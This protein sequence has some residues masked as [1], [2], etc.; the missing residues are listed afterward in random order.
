MSREFLLS[1]DLGTT[2]VRAI[3]FDAAGRAR[4][5]AFSP[6][7]VRYPSPGRVE[8]DATDMWDRSVEV[9]RRAIAEAG[10][11]AG[12]IAGIG[13]VTQRST[14]VAWDAETL[15]PIAPVIGWQDGR[16]AERVAGFRALGIPLN[17]LASATKFEWWM[18]NDDAVRAASSAGTLRL[19]TPDTWL[20]TKLTGGDA[21]VT[22]PGNAASTALF[23]NANGQWS[24][25]IV[26]LF[27]VPSAALAEVVPTNAIVGETP[28]DLLGAPVPVAARAGDQQASM[29]GQGAHAPG[30]EKI[31]LGTSAMVDVH[32]GDAP[33][34]AP[35]GAYALALWHLAGEARTYCLEGTVITAGSAI[36]WLIDLGLARDAEEAGALA[37]SVDTSAGVVFVPALQGLGTPFADDGARA[38]FYG[39]TRG[40]T[41][42]HLARAVLE[43][44]AHRCVDVGEALGLGNVAVRAG[45]GMARNDT[46]LQMIADYGGHDVLR[47]AEVEASALGAAFFA[48]IATGVFTGAEHCR[49]LLAAPERFAPA[50]DAT[51]RAAARERWASAIERTRG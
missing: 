30:D 39:L 10:I 14:A 45:G 40:A 26:D 17:T 11:G 18:Q 41:T 22:D 6:L 13:V 21:H 47:A 1:L 44:I 23:D 3:V 2:S 37:G 29:F 24:A 36:E 35:A 50:I 42:A 49:Q 20:T 19:G 51:A 5:R 32:T 25:P 43:G 7:A 33:H 9:M 8:Q 31:T 16:T 46:I 4:S 27:S 12:D 34:E 15:S 38:A 28:P 48:G